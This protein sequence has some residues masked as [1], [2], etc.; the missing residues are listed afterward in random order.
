MYTRFSYVNIMRIIYTDDSPRFCFSVRARFYHAIQCDCTRAHLLEA[1]ST[2]TCSNPASRRRPAAESPAM[3]P[4]TTITRALAAMLQSTTVEHYG[5]FED[6]FITYLRTCKPLLC[7]YLSV[8]YGCY[9]LCLSYFRYWGIWQI[10]NKA[11]HRPVENQ[12]P[13]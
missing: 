3:P 6:I 5:H 1:S 8:V 4:P 9:C 7:F 2:S 10:Y 12:D 13:K 11:H